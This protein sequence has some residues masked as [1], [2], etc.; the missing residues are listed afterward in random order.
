MPSIYYKKLKERLTLSLY[1]KKSNKE[2]N[3][4]SYYYY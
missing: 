3:L 2:A 4:C 1:I